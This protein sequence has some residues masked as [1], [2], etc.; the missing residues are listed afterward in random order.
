MS[1][2]VSTE[3]RTLLE[4]AERCRRMAAVTHHPVRMYLFELAMEIDRVA[5]RVGGAA[6]GNRAPAAE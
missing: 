2:T 5:D 4:L 1:D 6:V 3:L